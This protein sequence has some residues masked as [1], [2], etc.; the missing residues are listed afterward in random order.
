MNPGLELL[1][2]I[3]KNSENHSPKVQKFGIQKSKLENCF[4]ISF[5]FA[6]FG[7]KFPEVSQE[8]HFLMALINDPC[9]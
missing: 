4:E 3:S 9:P 8:I 2:K 7:T 6:L 5:I 1:L